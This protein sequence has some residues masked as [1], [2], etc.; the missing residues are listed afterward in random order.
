MEA[1]LPATA[2]QFSLTVSLFILTQGLLPL[3]WS[4]ISEV[5]G[6]RVSLC[7]LVV[8]DLILIFLVQ[9]VYILSLSIFMLG[10]IAVAVSRNVAS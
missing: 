9:L 1:D 5:K 2:S 8:D 3:V 7:H 6:R 4:A 10:S